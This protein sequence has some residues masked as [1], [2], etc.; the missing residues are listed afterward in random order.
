LAG[1]IIKESLRPEIAEVQILDG[2]GLPADGPDANA[3]LEKFSA[4][5]A[6]LSRRVQ[7]LD[8]RINSTG[9][10][11]HVAV[12][13]HDLLKRSRFRVVTTIEGM[14]MSLGAIIAQSGARR[15]MAS[16]GVFQMHESVV[17]ISIKQ[18][19]HGEW[20]WTAAELRAYADGLD[21]SMKD[22]I[23]IFTERTG[24]SDIRGMFGAY[25]NA[26]EARAANL[27]DE[28]VEARPLPG[29]FD[30]QTLHFAHHVRSALGR[31]GRP[32]NWCHNGTPVSRPVAV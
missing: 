14:G 16:D 7:E 8:L 17:M 3:V 12:G 24:R 28:V 15:R 26:E 1:F 20:A 31:R 18:C 5:L 25:L 21:I 29:G 23:G 30:W 19:P 9:G 11:S 13:I 32:V 22:Q 6:K 2:L 4:Q 10:S 27:I